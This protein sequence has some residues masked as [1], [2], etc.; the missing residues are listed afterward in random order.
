MGDKG[1]SKGLKKNLDDTKQ[2]YQ[3]AREI[4]EQRPPE[5]KVPVHQGLGNSCRQ[6]QHVS[7]EKE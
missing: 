6:D 4:K 7:R 5:T 1:G 3:Q 2:I